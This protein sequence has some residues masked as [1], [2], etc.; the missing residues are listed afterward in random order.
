MSCGNE[1]LCAQ[2]HV[3]FLVVAK[4]CCGRI[5]MHLSPSIGEN[6]GGHVFLS[7]SML[8]PSG[9][10]PQIFNHRFETTN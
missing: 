6:S 10:S 3:L 7:M 2:L 5:I 8:W 9:I 4:L 1:F